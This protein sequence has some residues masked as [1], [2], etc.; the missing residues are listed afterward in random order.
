[1]DR[2][3]YRDEIIVRLT[4]GLIDLELSNEALD[5]CIDSAFRQVQ[6]YI[7]TTVLRTLPY[8]G[9]I[10]LKDCGVSSVVRIYRTEGYMSGTGM[11]GSNSYDP[12]YMSMWQSMGGSNVA[13]TAMNNWTENLAAYNTAMQIRNT[14]STDLIFRFDKHTECLYVN[15]GFDKPQFITIEFV[16][17]YEDVS[18][19]VSDYW[20]DILVRLSLAICKQ[21]IG[22]IRKKFTQDNALWQLDT[23]ILTE[24]LEEEKELQ[25]ALRKASQLVYPL[26]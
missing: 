20:I 15:C 21:A 6:R 9:C 13:T 12:M 7:D 2:Q 1:M 17:R 18:E 19:V 25:E 8:S 24:G 16:P 26:D 10:D 3:A 4:G 5:R 14:L 23:D 11:S 22:R